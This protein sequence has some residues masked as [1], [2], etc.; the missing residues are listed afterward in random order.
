MM[1]PGSFFLCYNKN[2]DKLK[3]KASWGLVFVLGFLM[4][5]SKPAFALSDWL[6]EKYSDYQ[7][8]FYNAEQSDEE[9]PKEPICGPGVVLGENQNYAGEI[10]WSN[11]ELAAIEA[12]Q[13]IYEEAANEYGFPWQILAVLHSMEHNLMKDNP[14]N[15]Q[16]AYQLY[17]YTNGGRNENAFYPVGPIDDAEFLRQ[18]KIAASVVVGKVPASELSSNSDSVKRFFFLYNGAA[19]T[20]IQKAINMGFTA[21]QA[22]NGEGSVYVMNRYDAQRDPN[23]SEM[24]SYWPGRYVGDGRY[25]PNATSMVF[26]AFVKYMALGGESGGGYCNNSGSIVDTA[27]LLSWGDK[28]HA[29]D[30]PKPE[31][32]NAMKEVGNYFEPCRSEGDCAPIGASCDIFVST[33][34]RYSGA[35]S[36]FPSTNPSAQKDYMDSN[37]SMYSR[38]DAGDVSELQ[39]GDILV[40]VD[41]GRHIYIFLGNVDGEQ[42][43]AEASYNDRTAEHFSG[44]VSLTNYS[45]Y[46]RISGE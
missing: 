37:T 14:G 24:S 7:I 9:R 33:V 23:S 27:I 45:V 46:R 36:N 3:K 31:Y 25:D 18:S 44:A 1:M 16:G 10:V 29:K 17:T 21:E 11:A 19:R 6:M 40:K 12:N 38:V 26:G 30:D 13:P 2:M 8:Y 32:V 5:F 39:S 4:V 34:M 42:M 41:N 28:T 22:N 20:Y 35:D 43:K 15:G